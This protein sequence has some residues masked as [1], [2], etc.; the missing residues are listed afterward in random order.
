[1]TV[2]VFAFEPGTDQSET[3]IFVALGT[4]RGIQHFERAWSFE[5][6][7]YDAT[8]RDSSF[9]FRSDLSRAHLESGAQLGAWGSIDMRFRAETEIN[10]TCR[11]RTHTRT[12][13]AHGS[14]RF[15][16]QHDNGVFGTISRA[17]FTDAE[18]WTSNC[19]HGFPGGGGTP[20]CPEPSVMAWADM[21]HGRDYRSFFA[22]TEGFTDETGAESAIWQQF[23]PR[24]SVEHFIL[25]AVPHSGSR[26]A[27]MPFSG[28]ARRAGSSRARPPCHRMGSRTSM[29][30]TPV[31]ERR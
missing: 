26:R 12:G 21:F 3:D 31:P 1:L 15:T 11:G 24:M 28:G 29:V 14:F 20:R 7:G 16:P 18:L 23:F 8:I 25:A 30:P 6:H 19:H 2:Q 17:R 13:E 22:S 9:H 27:P 4:D 5:V 10:S